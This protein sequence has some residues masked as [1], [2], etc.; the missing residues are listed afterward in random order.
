MPTTAQSKY[1]IG[2]RAKNLLAQI[3]DPVT[4]SESAMK[5]CLTRKDGAFDWEADRFASVYYK[6]Q[7]CVNILDYIR[8]A[9]E[10]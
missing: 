9:N 10:I 5:L 8:K 4:E 7:E 2:Q 1:I 6:L 3:K